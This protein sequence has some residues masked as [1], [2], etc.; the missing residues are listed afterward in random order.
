MKKKEEKK[1]IKMSARIVVIIMILLGLILCV[2]GINLPLISYY[3]AE[4]YYEVSISE[5]LPISWL[6][7]FILTFVGLLVIFIEEKYL[8][9][10]A[11]G[12]LYGFILYRFTFGAGFA[13]LEGF[14]SVYSN[15]IGFYI[16]IIGVAIVVFSG[17]FGFINSF[18]DDFLCC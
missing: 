4:N 11:L 9:F 14:E 8:I 7:W 1:T 6:L 13:D 18:V 10:S 5:L 15:G 2:V 3:G 12:T 16:I 17:I